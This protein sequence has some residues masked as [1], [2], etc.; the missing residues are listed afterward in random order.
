M[1]PVGFLISRT[2]SSPVRVIVIVTS[3]MVMAML[4]PVFMVV[5][6]AAIRGDGQPTAQIS[7]HQFFHGC[8]GW[9]GAHDDPVLGEDGQ[10]ATAD[11]TGNDRSHSQLPQPT[12]ERPGLMLGRRQHA[13]A[14][15][16]L[17][18]GVDFDHGKMSAPAE[19]V[20]E[21]SVLNW[22]GDLHR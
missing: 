18:L 17:L 10:R 8:P 14:E 22:N 20:V 3:M 1:H 15:R 5:V 19:M 9:T 6:F 11:A 12:R 2:R 7:R 13:G 16:G 21:T 4:M